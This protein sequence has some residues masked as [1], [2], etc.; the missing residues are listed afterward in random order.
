MLRGWVPA[1]RIDEV[2]SQADSDGDGQLDVEELAYYIA[3]RKKQGAEKGAATAAAPSPPAA[4]K[5]AATAPSPA[6]APTT[7]TEASNSTT[8]Q[9]D[10][11]WAAEHPLVSSAVQKAIK[12]GQDDKAF[13]L[14]HPAV[15]T[16]V[17][18][19]LERGLDA[20]FA[21]EH[22]AVCSAIV[23]S[24]AS[25]HPNA[26]KV[27]LNA[28]TS[29]LDDTA[30]GSQ[31]GKGLASG[32]SGS[33]GSA[34]L[35]IPA[36]AESPAEQARLALNAFDLNGD[37]TLDADELRFM[38]CSAGKGKNKM[39]EDDFQK[40]WARLDA[41]KDGVLTVEELTEYFVEKQAQRRKGGSASRAL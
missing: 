41:N 25:N 17:A 16:A 37:G 22:P 35:V 8:E 7:V 24:I 14:Q 13:A 32:S 5:P 4:A 12:S 39:S 38:L 20:A 27:V 15:S 10:A 18:H 21:L 23:N 30:S 19:A 34:A 6:T 3:N 29:A 36:S 31:G 9:A 1:E 40:V 2:W 26:A 28:M 33:S 11:V